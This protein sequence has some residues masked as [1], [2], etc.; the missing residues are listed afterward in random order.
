MGKRERSL[1]RVA[2]GNLEHNDRN[3]SGLVERVGRYPM[4]L[5]SFYEGRGIGLQ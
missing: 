2:G 5:G 3:N 1:E 4:Y